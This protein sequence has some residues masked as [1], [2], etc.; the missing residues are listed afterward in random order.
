MKLKK[1]IKLKKKN[2]LSQLELTCQA[3]NP[4]HEIRIIS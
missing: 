2:Y 1:N 4:S 3:R